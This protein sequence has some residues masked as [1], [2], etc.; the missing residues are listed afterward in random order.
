MVNEVLVRLTDKLVASSVE[1][2]LL[3]YTKAIFFSSGPNYKD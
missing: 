3:N 2:V 1:S